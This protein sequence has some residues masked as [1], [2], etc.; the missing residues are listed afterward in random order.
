[1]LVPRDPGGNMTLSGNGMSY[2]VKVN[3]NK[4]KTKEE[5]ANFL[6]QQMLKLALELEG[7]AKELVNRGNKSG[8]NPSKPGEPPK[9]VSGILKSNISHEVKRERDAVVGFLGVRK[10]PA[11]KY[12]PRLEFGFYGQVRRK[13]SANL[14]D[15]DKKVK[16]TYMVHQSPRPFL[17]PTITKN[18][19]LILKR[20]SGK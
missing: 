6:E 9:T 12:A 19:D 3:I 16:G 18:R 7:F 17:R 20:L 10:G 4:A 5:L 11:S 8:K 14:S 15:L 2:T 13:T 1:M